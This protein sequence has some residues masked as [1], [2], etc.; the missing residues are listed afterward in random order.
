MTVNFNAPLITGATEGGRYAVAVVT[1]DGQ[2]ILDL[3]GNQLG[4]TEASMTIY[5]SPTGGNFAHLFNVFK[6]ENLVVPDVFTGN[7]SGLDV[8]LANWAQTHKSVVKFTVNPDVKV[9]VLQSVRAAKWLGAN[10]NLRIELEFDEPLAAF[11]GNQVGLYGGEEIFNL[12]N[13]NFAFGSDRG[14]TSGTTL[15][16]TSVAYNVIASAAGGAT[17]TA[18]ES[19][20]GGPPLAVFPDRQVLRLTATDLATGTFTPSNLTAGQVGIEVP[21][22]N[23]KILYLWIGKGSGLVTGLKEIKARAVNVADPAGNA[24]SVESAN[25]DVRT[26]SID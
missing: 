12:G 19:V 15:S 20:G 24:I 11:G 4:T 5:P 13:Y 9:P 8:G 17:V 6:T 16:G 14:D 25:A 2:R 21:G 26:G 7:L 1:G 3:Q 22:S 10:G 23:P 18:L